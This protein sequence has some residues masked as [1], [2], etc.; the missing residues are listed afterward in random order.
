MGYNN[1]SGVVLI[2]PSSPD[3]LDRL[4]YFYSEIGW[5]VGVDDEAGRSTSVS[6]P[7]EANQ[8]PTITYLQEPISDPPSQDL[9]ATSTY[10]P[11]FRRLVEVSLIVPRNRDVNELLK[12]GGRLLQRSIYEFPDRDSDCLSFRFTDPFNYLIGVRSRTKREV[13]SELADSPYVSPL[14]KWDTDETVPVVTIDNLIDFAINSSGTSI[15]AKRAFRAITAAAG[16]QPE[17][18]DEFVERDE[19]QI[20]GLNPNKLSRLLDLIEQSKTSGRSSIYVLNLGPTS[21]A[22][23]KNLLAE[24]FPEN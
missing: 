3:N 17:D 14:A 23:L 24:L 15:V 8:A 16:R 19:G 13:V 21:K 20:V 11:E 1:R 18:F 5:H 22:L 2:V 7:L 9:E 6:P 10:L 4:D 12:L